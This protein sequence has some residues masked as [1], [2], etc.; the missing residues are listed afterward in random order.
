MSSRVCDVG[1]LMCLALSR[2]R[3]GARCGKMLGFVETVQGGCRPSKSRT[4]HSFHKHS[5]HCFPH[6]C[7]ASVQQLSFCKRRQ[8][9]H[10]QSSS[11][12]VNMQTFTRSTAS[13][14]ST[15]SKRCVQVRKRKEI[16]SQRDGPL[17]NPGATHRSQL[18]A[19]LEQHAFALQ[20]YQQMQCHAS[21]PLAGQCRSPPTEGRIRGP[22]IS[23]C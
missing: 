17:P 22:S 1:L 4:R 15:S 3:R 2:C 6:R 14:T 7:K 10:S 18:C 12:L 13:A 9:A 11:N 5:S 8:P 16:N 21:C 23:H 20:L 19:A